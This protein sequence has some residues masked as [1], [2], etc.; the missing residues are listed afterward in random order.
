[1]TTQLTP[2]SVETLGM[3]IGGS[4]VQAATG[5]LE[6]IFNPATGEIIARVPR[7]GPQ[8]VDRAVAAAK[9][10]FPAWSRTTP[11]ERSLVLLKMADVMEQNLAELGRIESANAGKPKLQSQHDLE[12]CVDALRFY[13]GAARILDGMSAGEYMDGYTSYVRR[14]PIGVV[15][16]IAPWNYPLAMAVFKFAPA[17]AAGN[18][19]ITK[20][21]EQTPLSLLK[22]A[23]LTQHLLPDGVFQVV[24]GDGPPV[25]Q[26]LVEHPDV[27]F[28]SL[29]GDV[30]TGR[31]IATAGA[32]TLTRTHL[33]LGGKAPVV[34][35]D[36]A[37]LD[38]LKAI[39][40]VASFY[41]GGQDCTA[42]C[43][44]IA[45]PKVFDQVVSDL[46]DSAQSLK[47]GNPV[48]HDDLDLGSLIS[49][50]QQE[51]VLGFLD[52]ARDEKAEILTGGETLDSKGAFV[53]PAVVVGVGQDHDIVRR[54]VFGPVVTVQR[55][56]DDEQA[57]EWA[58][59]T[60]YGLS[61]SVFTE[62]HSR[63]MNATR[64]LNFGTVWVNDH[65]LATPELPH[66]GFK[67]S[68]YGK[69]LS[70]Y[71]LDDYTQ[72]KQ[73][74]HRIR[75]SVWSVGQAGLIN[76]GRKAR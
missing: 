19:Q 59:A 43:R 47:I 24:T 61:S 36:D 46:V 7:G 6:D 73:V 60:R 34:I 49:K 23:E 55:F 50:R 22:F 11:G 39:L 29:T 45:G 57:F 74:T 48:E 54:E 33:E 3:L 14:E 30:G 12:L 42:A 58:N 44:V 20:P 56:D 4:W 17:I 66:G 13:A 9:A 8:D 68:G 37:D 10:A 64:R 18:V 27:A 71:G 40:K 35:F 41:N 53:T 5:E 62:N 65:W 28:V 38:S 63:A 75:P 51:R 2:T 32:P 69:D 52:R 67:D 31:T 16:G 70:K 1:M 72:I 25:G 26:A 21:S 15:A 76:E